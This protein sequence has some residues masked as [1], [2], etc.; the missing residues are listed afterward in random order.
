MARKMNGTLRRHK[1]ELVRC[2]KVVVVIDR[3]PQIDWPIR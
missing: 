3:L 1:G 2:V